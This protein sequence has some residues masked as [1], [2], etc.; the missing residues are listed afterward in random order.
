[1]SILS[2]LG[3]AKLGPVVSF[4]YWII[5]IFAATFLLRDAA[6]DVNDTSLPVSWSLGTAVRSIIDPITLLFKD[7]TTMRLTVLYAVTSYAFKVT[8]MAA[9]LKYEPLIKPPN[10]HHILLLLLVMLSLFMRNVL[11]FCTIPLVVALYTHFSPSTFSGHLA[12]TLEKEKE[13]LEGEN[14][15]ESSAPET[16]QQND[17]FDYA[18]PIWRLELLMTRWS[19]AAGAIGVLAML[20]G[21]SL[22]QFCTGAV[23]S[24]FVL[25]SLA[26]PAALLTLQ[27]PPSEMSRVLTGL[28]L[29]D[30]LAP[31]MQIATRSNVQADGETKS[32]LPVEPTF[33]VVMVLLLCGS[34]GT[35][36]VRRKVKLH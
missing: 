7:T 4:L 8:D 21:D 36:Y 14:V 11:V 35:R 1:M 27:T 16:T 10:S 25:S 28:A 32:I 34:V 18:A 2:V 31:L 15:K 19:L 17:P 9:S 20:A 30:A 12:V 23:L 6:P 29:I 33:V 5:Y 3:Y 13:V 24:G 26:S 22:L